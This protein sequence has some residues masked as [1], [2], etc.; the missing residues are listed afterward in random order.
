MESGRKADGEIGEGRG[1]KRGGE[2]KVNSVGA[3]R[4]GG[5]WEYSLL[6]SQPVGNSGER[7]VST[8][9]K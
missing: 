9:V 1:K 5:E 6:E 4:R 7:R 8:L 2:G 3:G